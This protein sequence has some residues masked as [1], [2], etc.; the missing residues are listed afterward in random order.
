M[1]LIE[2]IRSAKTQHDLNVL[3]MEVIIGPNM[4]DNLDAFK[5]KAKELEDE[6]SKT[7]FR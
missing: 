2:K 1:K 5:A 4:R 3:A 6:N 7:P